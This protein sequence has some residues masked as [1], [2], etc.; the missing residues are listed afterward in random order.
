MFLKNK[1]KGKKLKV[2]RITIGKHFKKMKVKHYHKK[3]TY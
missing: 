3:K 2:Y 1:Q